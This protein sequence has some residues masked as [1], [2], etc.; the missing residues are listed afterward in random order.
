M[1]RL[2]AEAT[3]GFGIIAAQLADHVGEI[4][5]I[6]VA[7]PPQ[8]RE[9]AARDQIE[10]VDQ[11]RHAR[12]VA[13]GFLGLQ[14]EAF[15]KIARADAGRI[16]GLDDAEHLLDPHQRHAEP[17]RDIEQRGGQIAAL[18]DLVDQVRG[19][20]QVGPVDRGAGLG[21]QMVRQAERGIGKTVEIGAVLP[22]APAA[23]RP[24]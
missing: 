13:V 24:V 2:S 22:R 3:A 11:P 6:D 19:D 10:I 20:E 1:R 14:R 12:I 9:I 21:E 23:V 16:E 15:G 5:V 7:Q 4:L 17:R 8:P 18:V